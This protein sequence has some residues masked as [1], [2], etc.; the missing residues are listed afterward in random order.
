MQNKKKKGGIAKSYPQNRKKT[1]KSPTR[2]TQQPVSGKPC[3]TGNH[4]H[5][6]YS[7]TNNV[8][9]LNDRKAPPPVL[10]E[11]QICKIMGEWDE[12]G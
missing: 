6:G 1:V 9:V 7:Q 12:P 4:S 3:S 11:P 8:F 10:V 2:P 5:N